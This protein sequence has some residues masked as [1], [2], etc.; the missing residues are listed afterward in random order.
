VECTVCTPDGRT[1]R[2]IKAGTDSRIILPCPHCAAW[3]TPEREHLTGW[4]DAANVVEAGQKASLACP[5]CGVL[6]TE[7][8]RAQANQK[9]KLLHKGQSITQDGSITGDPPGTHTLGFRYTAANNL[10]MDM[11]GVAEVEWNAPRTTDSE[12]ADKKLRQFFW[13][14]PSE[15][16]AI[17]LSEMDAAHIAGRSTD[18][19]RGRV[20]MDATEITVGIDIGK[21][22]CHWVAAAWRTGAAPHVLEY[23]RMEVPSKEMAE[24]LAI[25]TA[26]RRFRDE[27]CLPGWPVVGVGST[28]SPQAGQNV[29]PRVVLVDSGNWES[30]VVA[31]CVESAG[32]FLPSNGFGVQQLAKRIIY[33]DPGYEVVPQPAGHALVE[34]N[35]DWWKSQVHSRLQTPIG[36]PG[37]LTLFH[38]SPTEHLSFAK[39][40]T[41]ERQVQEFVA[42]RGLVTR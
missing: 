10:L 25:L 26:L 33:H 28:G 11:A 12:L 29:R 9:A 17:T 7:P 38:A 24:E 32:V 15:P 18:L 21:W 34:I 14:L 31:F 30:A 13:T 19:P 35:T 22:L 36:Q 1:W 2:E 39:H 23:G 27:V 3:V 5:A 16:E 37:A 41:A 4:Q 8:E 40:L 42:G 6:W 20:P